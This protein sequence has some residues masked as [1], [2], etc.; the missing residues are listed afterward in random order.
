MSED[1]SPTVNN[2]LMM[3]LCCQLFS[4]KA[5]KY[6]S[7]ISWNL[8]LSWKMCATRLSF[9]CSLSFLFDTS[10]Q[11]FNFENFQTFRKI[12]RIVQWILTYPLPR[13][14]NSQ[15]QSLHSLY[16]FVS[17][18]GHWNSYPIKPGYIFLYLFLL[19]IY[20]YYMFEAEKLCQSTNSLC[21]LDCKP[22]IN[23]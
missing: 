16:I 15:F 1:A 2:V 6:Y 3:S 21:C 13:F 7:I 14:I 9:L 19:I 10:S 8:L 5:L 17:F 23:F 22:W 12:A 20:Q 18:L 11:T 4:L